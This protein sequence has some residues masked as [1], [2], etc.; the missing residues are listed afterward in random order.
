M[1]E[2]NNTSAS[3]KPE[4]MTCMYKRECPSA[5]KAKIWYYCDPQKNQT[6]R[7]RNCK[8]NP[9]SLWQVCEATDKRECAMLDKK[10]EPIARPCSHFRPEDAK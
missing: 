9:E 6:C 10:G 1:S 2:E 3:Q 7:R 8:Y 4:C 5:R